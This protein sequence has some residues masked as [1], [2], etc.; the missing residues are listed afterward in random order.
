[1][2]Q[3][4]SDWIKSTIHIIAPVAVVGAGPSLGYTSHLLKDYEMVIGVNYVYK[5]VKLDYLVVTHFMLLLNISKGIELPDATLVYSDYA[6]D[7]M[8]QGSTNPTVPG[9]RFRE[10]ADLQCGTSTIIPAIDLACQMG[11]EVHLFGVDLCKQDGAQYCD[12]Y[13]T[14]K[15]QD[16]DFFTGWAR[17]VGLQIDALRRLTGKQ[18]IQIH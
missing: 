11:S 5:L 2:D 12:G 18:I 4:F 15:T 10:Y 3:Y 6:S 8:F 16:D 14:N 1:M 13:Q 7:W 9:I 17:V